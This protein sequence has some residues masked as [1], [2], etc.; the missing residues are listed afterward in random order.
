[1]EE[2]KAQRAVVLTAY[3]SYEGRALA[4]QVAFGF[5]SQEFAAAAGE[6]W[7]GAINDNQVQGSYSTIH[8]R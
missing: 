7:A 8:I 1:M 2:T 3:S 5:S 4:M 6:R